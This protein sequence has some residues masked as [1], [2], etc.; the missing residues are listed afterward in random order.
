MPVRL[1][2]AQLPVRLAALD[3][4]NGLGAELVSDLI[5]EFSE[6]EGLSMARN[7]DQSGST[8]DTTGATEGLRGLDYYPSGSVA[9]F[10]SSGS[11]MTDGL[12]DLAT[13][14]LESNVPDYNT[15]TA[16]ASG[17]PAAYW[18][19][20][21]TAWYMTPAFIQILRELKDTAGLPLFLD[22][23]EPGEGGAVGSI[24][25]WRVIPN[26]YM[27]EDYPLY[28]ANWP[29]FLTIADVAEMSVQMMEETAPGFMTLYAEK[30]LCSTVRDPFAGVR[31]KA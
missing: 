10:G 27:S 17:L 19:L 29:R 23:G 25:G 15:I 11:A 3:D 18:G 31:L 6:Q 28:L 24:F 21:G 20:A 13:I 4:I 1:I 8:T 26:P 30:R 2:A 7:D 12:H 5:G 9:A 14:D 16:L 22:L